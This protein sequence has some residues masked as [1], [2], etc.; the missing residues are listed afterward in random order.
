MDG[1]KS[2]LDTCV[3][4]CSKKEWDSAKDH[5]Q[6]MLADES[7]LR[8]VSPELF[9]HSM[10]KSLES[11]REAIPQG[12]GGIPTNL[13]TCAAECF[14][15]LRQSC[16][17]NAQLQSNINSY[18]ALLSNAKIIMEKVISS[19]PDSDKENVLKCAAQFL[20]NACVSNPENQKVVWNTFLQLFKPMLLHQDIKVCD[21]TCMVVHTCLNAAACKDQAL[22]T[23]A[24]AQDIVL[25][26]IQ[27][28]AQRDVE[29]GLY[30]LEDMLKNDLF[31]PKL[32][33]R[34]GEK[35]RLL[36]LEVILAEMNELP[37]CADPGKQEQDR[38]RKEDSAH[39]DKDK[40][41]NKSENG[42]SSNSRTDGDGDG[43]GGG[44]G[45]KADDS[46]VPAGNGANGGG[47]PLAV[48]T[49]NLQFIAEYVKRECNLLLEIDKSEAT[50]QEVTEE[51]SM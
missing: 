9:L 46:P 15:C 50:G 29:W 10:E 22:M 26:S 43:D 16:A 24:V 12:E 49:G 48:S 8:Q 6:K 21:Y 32:F 19:D 33:S 35:E 25:A 3:V 23:G 30:V 14:R 20:G 47:Q 7:G 31:L 18:T 4:Q 42:N 38:N 37:A 44:G 45:D 41:K 51:E 34:M 27:A 11:M 2:L 5:F 36:L 28:T 39:A 1:M 40:D 17:L 13:A